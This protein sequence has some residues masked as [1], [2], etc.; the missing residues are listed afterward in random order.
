MWKLKPK[1]ESK[2]QNLCSCTLGREKI[3]SDG[4]F[5]AHI[6]CCQ[7]DEYLDISGCIPCTCIHTQ[8]RGA[9]KKI[10]TTKTVEKIKKLSTVKYLNKEE[11]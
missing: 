11:N 10:K 5:G 8:P 9:P 1:Y 7:T 2:I 6:F 3:S 4:W